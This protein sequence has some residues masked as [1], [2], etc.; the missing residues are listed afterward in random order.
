MVKL[1]SRWFGLGKS[2]PQRHPNRSPTYR[3]AVPARRAAGVVKVRASLANSPGPL[4]PLAG[5][6]RNRQFE[7]LKLSRR[8]DPPSSP[9]PP[10]VPRPPPPRARPTLPP[11]SQGPTPPDPRPEPT[12]QPRQPDPKNDHPLHHP[13]LHALQPLL[14]ARQSGPPLPHAAAARGARRRHGHYDGAAAADVGGTE[15]FVH[16]VQCVPFHCPP[17]PPCPPTLPTQL[18]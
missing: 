11:S 8:A 15:Q 4:A 1:S 16:Q 9:P 17:Y 14:P 13:R 7:N 6:R 5:R 3:P 10:N 18:K 2:K 12:R